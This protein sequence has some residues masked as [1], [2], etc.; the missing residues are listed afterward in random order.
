MSLAVSLSFSPPLLVCTR[1]ILVH[2]LLSRVSLRSCS[3][4]GILFS[5]SDCMIFINLPS[6]LLISSARSALLLCTKIVSFDLSFWTLQVQNFHLV[7]FSNFFL[8]ID[9]LYLMRH[10]Q[11]TSFNSVLQNIYLFVAAPALRCLCGLHTAVA[12]L[13]VKCR[14]S[15]YGARA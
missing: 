3:V 12:C 9:I 14:L 15:S 8:F 7:L 10:C 2:W 6:S 11:Y 1:H 5:R 13:V 4:F